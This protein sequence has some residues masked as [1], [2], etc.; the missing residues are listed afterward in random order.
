MEP[1][2]LEEFDKEIRSFAAAF[3]RTLGDEAKLQYYRVLS[4]LGGERVSQ[5]LNWAIE[6]LDTSLPS[7]ARLRRRG[8]E[9]G[10]FAKGAGENGK[11]GRATRRPEPVFIRITCPKCDGEIVVRRSKLAE[12]A[13]SGAEYD[14][15]NRLH[16]GCTMTWHAASILDTGLKPAI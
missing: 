13:A 4:P 7:I 1:M 2:K 12:D 10:W 5:L 8:L 15:P 3:G 14:C 16:W 9:L 11:S 6:T